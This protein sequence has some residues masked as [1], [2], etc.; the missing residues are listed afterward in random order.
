ML[1]SLFTSIRN[2]F[3]PTSFVP[4]TTVTT[5]AKPRAS[6]GRPRD[7]KYWVRTQLQ[8]YDGNGTI[9]LE[10]PNEISNMQSARSRVSAFLAREFGPGRFA[11]KSYPIART[12]HVRPKR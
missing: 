6:T 9:I 4:T 2:L 3:R 12:I 8:S 5:D 7:P 1:S 10:V 11:T